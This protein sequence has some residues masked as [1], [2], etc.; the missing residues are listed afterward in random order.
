MSPGQTTKRIT[1]VTP[2][3]SSGGAERALV[4]LARGF[5]EKGYQVD[6][7]TLTGVE[8]DF[9]QLPDGVRR[10]ALDI[11]SPSSNLAQALWNNFHRGLILRRAIHALQP[12]VVI[13][14]LSATSVLT[15]V[16]LIATRFIVIANEQASIQALQSALWYY[17][18]RITFPLAHKVVSVSDGVDNDFAWLPARKR[19]VIYNP[20]T[21][22]NYDELILDRLPSGVDP[23]KKWLV[24]MGRLVKQKN[25]PLL[26]K[27]FKTIA[28]KYPDWQLLIFGEGHLQAELEKLKDDFDLN[29]R[30]VFPGVTNNPFAIFKHSQLFVMSSHWEGLPTVLFEALSCGL[31]V[32]STDCPSGPREIIR[33]GI[34]GILVPTDDV[35]ALAAAM[36]RLMSDEAE[37]QRFAA[38]APEIRERFSLKEIVAKWES[39]ISETIAQTRK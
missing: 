30:V 18:I 26:L 31:P 14:F 8:H 38:R 39:L 35:S 6:V 12:D 29:N 10:L 15:L 16:A 20:L 2:S 9:Y 19:A 23:D 3:L 22:I 5:L 21:P 28:D 27:A 17:S 13:S 36:S 24:A 7:I 25:F 37:R 34:D 11:S 4:L 1:L 33:D 32:I